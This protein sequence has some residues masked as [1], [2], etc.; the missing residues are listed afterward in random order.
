MNTSPSSFISGAGML[1]GDMVSGWEWH[2]TVHPSG[3]GKEGRAGFGR[4][5][6][7]PVL[8][9]DHAAVPGITEHREPFC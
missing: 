5:L 2:K 3:R 9:G 4:G 7:G 6:M 1:V 8:E